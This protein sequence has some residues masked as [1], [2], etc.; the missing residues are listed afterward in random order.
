MNRDNVR[1]AGTTWLRMRRTEGRLGDTLADHAIEHY[2]TGSIMEAWDEFT[3]WEEAPLDLDEPR[4]EFLTVFQD[5]FQFNW[6]PDNTQYDEEDDLPEM[7]VAMHYLEQSAGAVD[8]F[9]RRFIEEACSQPFSFF[10]VT[11]AEPGKR[12]TIRDLLCKREFT[13]HERRASE[14]LR[15]GE[16]IFARVVTLDG[17]SIMLGCAPCAIPASYANYFF[18][19][20]EDIAVKGLQSREL[21]HEWDFELREIYFDIR[22]DLYD[23]Q[24]PA[25]RNTDDDPLQLTKLHYDLKCM[26]EEARDAL[27]PLTLG[28]ADGDLENTAKFDENGR[29]ASVEFPWLRQGNERN[30]AWSNTALGRIV[31]N[32]VK[33]TVE[34]NSENRAEAFKR[35]MQ[36]RLGGRAEF[37]QAVL[38]SLEKMY[39]DLKANPGGAEARR[40][41]AGGRRTDELNAR[42]EVRRMLEQKAAEHW[43]GWL[44]ESLPALNG[45]TPRE[46]AKSESGRER[47]EALLWDFELRKSGQPF[48]P[49]VDALRKS[50]GIG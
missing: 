21:L 18:D 50:L 39:E 31:I 27:A 5:W 7:P 40:L 1:V 42:P 46:A 4:P 12:M 24:L 9:T 33:L 49:D 3:L 35:E 19:L 37:K 25:L 41:D 2:G 30:K 13:V 44:D 48:D 29:L 8:S 6:V 43:R 22:N 45:E 16:I 10:M 23:P 47:L 20:R 11:G 28:M 36:E 14:T 32:G 38:T 26:P 17:D 15:K 34:V